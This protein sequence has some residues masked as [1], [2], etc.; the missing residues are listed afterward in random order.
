MLKFVSGWNSSVLC[1]SCVWCHSSSGMLHYVTYTLMVL[2]TIA[3]VQETKM[4]VLAP[5]FCNT[6]V[7]GCFW[8]SQEKSWEMLD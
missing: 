7:T 5:F 8:E 2:Y 4:S 3:S 6:G 1:S